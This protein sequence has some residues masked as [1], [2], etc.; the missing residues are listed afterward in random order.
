MPAR[1][2]NS[3]LKRRRSTPCLD[4]FM[5]RRLHHSFGIPAE[6]LIAQSANR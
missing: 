3:M 2:G 1:P 6:V 4:H 5:I